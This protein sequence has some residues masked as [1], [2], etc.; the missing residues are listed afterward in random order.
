[1]SSQQTF[2]WNVLGPR[3]KVNLTDCRQESI[4]QALRTAGLSD[5]TVNNVNFHQLTFGTRASFGS[6]MITSM[7]YTRSKRRHNHAIKFLDPKTAAPVFG[8]VQ[9]FVHPLPL[10]HSSAAAV[11]SLLDTTSTLSFD[12]GNNPPIPEII[13]RHLSSMADQQCWLEITEVPDS[14]VTIP[15]E[16]IIEKC[17]LLELDHCRVVS[18]MPNHV[19]VD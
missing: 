13:Q 7:D 2:S 15:L 18:F 8:L 17:V 11:V 16:T 19:E 4:I 12:L 5:A 6:M 1:M 10:P 9:C 14:W 3:S